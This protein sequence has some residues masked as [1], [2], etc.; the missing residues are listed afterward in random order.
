MKETTF[1]NT[2]AAIN[3]VNILTKFSNKYTKKVGRSLDKF[4]RGLRQIQMINDL[5]IKLS[6]MSLWRK[7]ALEQT[8]NLPDEIKRFTKNVLIAKYREIIRQYL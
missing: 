2:T 1:G 6:M 8:E 5:D 3:L 4:T 7:A